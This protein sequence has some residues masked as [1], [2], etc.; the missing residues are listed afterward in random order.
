MYWSRWS[1]HCMLLPRM[2]YDL[3]L[4]Y[5]ASC[6]TDFN[7]S[8]TLLHVRYSQSGNTS[9]IRQKFENFRSLFVQK[10]EFRF[11]VH[12]DRYRDFVRLRPKRIRRVLGY[13]QSGN[14]TLITPLFG[15]LHW[16][17]APQLIDYRYVNIA[18]RC[19]H[20]LAPLYLWMQFYREYSTSNQ[21]TLI[22]VFDGIG[23]ADDAL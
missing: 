13:S 11:F 12:R 15:D 7:L 18:F 9:L 10:C 1:P 6:S 14:T 8:W 20:G 5:H 23:S 2:Y 21:E 22:C 17:R 19:F 4:A 16:L 3:L